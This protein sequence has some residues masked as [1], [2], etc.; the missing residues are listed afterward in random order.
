MPSP[1]RSAPGLSA[2]LPGPQASDAK[3]LLK[4]LAQAGVVDGE[5]TDDLFVELQVAFLL[6][7]LG[8]QPGQLVL[9]FLVG[10]LRCGGL[11]S[12]SVLA[13]RRSRRSGVGSGGRAGGG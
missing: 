3:V 8:A 12:Q 7:A 13:A 9:E 1:A 5:L 2:V 11:V 10:S 4:L 6:V